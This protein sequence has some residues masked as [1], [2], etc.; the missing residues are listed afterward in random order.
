MAGMKGKSGGARPGAG[1]PRKQH[2]ASGATY[3][4]AVDYLAAVVAGDELPDPARVAAA[5]ALLPFQSP[6]QRA[7]LR[8]KPPRQ[9]Q[10][11]EKI[12]AEAAARDEWTQKAAAIRARRASSTPGDS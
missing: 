2:P 10:D 9:L 12:A 6:R 3:A 5:K 7:P 4:S 11:S 1:K 8:S